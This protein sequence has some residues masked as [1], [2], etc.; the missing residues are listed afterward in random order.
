MNGML[1]PI[2]FY[3]IAF[4]VIVFAILTVYMK[5]IFHS[6]LSAICVFFLAGVIFYI[7]GSEYNAIIQIAIYGVAVPIIIGIAVMFTNLKNDINSDNKVSPFAYFLLLI[8]GIF[9]IALIYLIMTSL[10]VNPLGFNINENIDN[11]SVK[12]INSFAQ[13]IFTR[14]VWAF[15]LLSLILTIVV[16]GLTLFNKKEEKCKK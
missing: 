2:V 10:L 5:N 8:C 12:V 7:L 16:A 15:E 11:T 4:F 9:I 13:G 6:L 3:P 14:Y 1:N